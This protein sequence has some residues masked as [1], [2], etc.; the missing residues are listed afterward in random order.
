M[1]HKTPEV[2]LFWS[3]LTLLFVSMFTI[4]VLRYSQ[5]VAK[6]TTLTKTT[7]TPPQSARIRESPFPQKPDEHPKKKSI[8]PSHSKFTVHAP[9]V[10]SPTR[11][12]Q[13]QTIRREVD[14]GNS[15]HAIELLKRFLED[16]PSHEVALMELAM[17]QLID[18]QSPRMAQETF[19]SILHINPNHQM[20]LIELLGLYEDNDL[21]DEGCQFLKEIY[22]RTPHA[23]KIALALGQFY[24]QENNQDE[25][26]IWLERAALQDEEKPTALS[27]LADIWLEMGYFQKSWDIFERLIDYYHS[28]KE[29]S[30]HEQAIATRIGQLEML[31]HLNRFEEAKDNLSAWIQNSPP[32]EQEPLSE[33]MVILKKAQG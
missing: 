19:E 8:T 13:L 15:D 26:L 29:E 3:G 28:S 2:R 30:F 11:D 22:E 10:T 4:G 21:I 17:I 1:K 20:A 6:T 18:Q 5:P 25:A 7:Y 14:K 24:A 31:I 32:E 23:S 33:L 27:M 16:D 12:I 9:T